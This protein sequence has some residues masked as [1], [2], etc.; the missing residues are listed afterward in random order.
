[1]NSPNDALPFGVM[2]NGGLSYGYKSEYLFRELWTL[3]S[4]L[5]LS[6]YAHA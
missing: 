4:V 5:L 6:A 2:H 3:R 1:M